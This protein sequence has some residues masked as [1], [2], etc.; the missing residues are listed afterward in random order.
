MLSQAETTWTIH[1]AAHLLNRA[2]FGGSPEEIRKFHAMG[3]EKAV[4]HLLGA[5]DGA[6]DFPKPDWAGLEHFL[7]ETR[8]RIAQR[9]EAVRGAAGNTP[10]EKEELRRKFQREVQQE[11]RRRSFD[12]QAWW[13]RRMVGT[14][15]PLREK[16][17]LFWH[18]HFATSM[19]KVREPYL[20]L[21]QNELFRGHALG[22]FH[23][24]TRRMVENPA[25][26]IY[27]D[28]QRSRKSNPNENFAREV[29]E[30]FTL[31]EGNYSEEDIREAAR[32]FTGYSLDSGQGRA[33][34][35]RRQW[36]DSEKVL[37][38]KR[39]HF[40]GQGVVDVIFEQP[41]VAGFLVRKLWVFFV[42]ENPPQAAVDALAPVFRKSGFRIAPILRE[43]FLSQEFY[44]ETAIRSQIKS[45]VQFLVQMIKQLEIG[46]V[47][48]GFPVVSQQQLGQVLFHPPN[49]AGWDWGQAWINTNTLLA[50]YNSAGFLTKGSAGSMADGG[51]GGQ[52][53][54]MRGAAKAMARRWEGP[55]YEVIAPRGLRGS[56]EKLVDDL[57]FR[58]FQGPV[59]ANARG[60]F[61]GYADAKR[62]AVF[63]NKEVGELCHLM[64]STPYYQ[65]C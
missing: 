60:N 1:E 48:E 58:F 13:F 62:G 43:I 65:L 18:D 53:G 45:P 12:A 22:S 54:M 6:G 14:K 20:M 2:G 25:M 35:N 8:E 16:M 11:S 44:S 23:E 51:G 5:E 41:A 63:T 38:G 27:L 59:P 55:D 52:G 15:A 42:Y 36:D 7:S 3:R 34:H 19:Q 64:L 56:S 26:M 50:R 10:A 32:A 30:L 57:L 21:E 33:V 28:L 31:G 37:F 17:T 46:S 24:L 49:V 47:P 61:I 40:D 9:R 4:D 39:G 29:M